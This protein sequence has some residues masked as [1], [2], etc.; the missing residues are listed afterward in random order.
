MKWLIT[1][2]NGQLGS[3]MQ[4]LLNDMGEPFLA[5]DVSQLDITDSQAVDRLLDDYQP[6]VVV[7][8]AAY[9]AVD[10]AESDSELAEK[11]N[12]VGPANLASWCDRNDVWLAHVSTDYV[13]AGNGTIAYKESDNVSPAS[14]YGQTKLDGELAV[15][16]VCTKF[17]TLRTAWVFSEYGNNFV[18]TM[19]RLAQDREELGVVADQIGC[20]TYAGDIAQAIVS[21]IE[22]ANAG[23]AETGLYHY[24]GDIAVSWWAFARE[25]HLA[26][27]KMGIIS[28]APT[29]KAI[30]TADYPTP[31]ARPPFSVLDCSK[32]TSAGVV[33]S[34]WR[35]AVEKVLVR[36]YKPS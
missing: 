32:A 30:T 36:T 20:P 5:V 25:V 21:L 1:G 35:T 24:T 17:I 23:N 15:S 31:A 9:T 19:V 8:A 28:K 6:E 26:A 12:V 18:K 22:A 29:L 2:A 10:K 16:N 14:V 4:D 13:F 27:E 7:N 11:V 33:C 3:C 34:D